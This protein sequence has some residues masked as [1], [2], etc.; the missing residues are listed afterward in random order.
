[1]Q[2]LTFALLL[3]S[4]INSSHGIGQA[5]GTVHK[6]FYAIYETVNYDTKLKQTVPSSGFRENYH[7]IVTTFPGIKL[8]YSYT[9]W[10]N[11]G[12][13]EWSV[14]GI[15]FGIGL[16]YGKS[17]MNADSMG[18]MYID[19]VFSATPS[20]G[21]TFFNYYQPGNQCSITDYG[22]NMHFDA[23]TILYAGV[24]LD[25]GPSRI[26]FTDNRIQG[27]EV[28][29]T[30]WFVNTRLQMGMSVPLPFAL[31][32]YF[33]LNCKIYG[34]LYGWSGRFY[35]LDWVAEDKKLKNFSV[36]DAQGQPLGLGFSLTFL[37]E[38]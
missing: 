11:L 6:G 7:S 35:K 13:S 17:I 21:Q 8:G 33:K 18:T 3:Y 20:N 12:M 22:L 34:V 38:D 2:R 25:A 27:Q 26:V 29:S 24:E 37:F 1:M 32:S 10:G 9:A 5:D 16:S 19:P 28:R 30:G 15:D 36:L 23:G 31:N 4:L 14:W